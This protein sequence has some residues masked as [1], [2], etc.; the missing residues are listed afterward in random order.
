V[1]GLPGGLGDSVGRGYVPDLYLEIQRSIKEAGGGIE[2]IQC[3]ASNG[4]YS[5]GIQQGLNQVELF[6]RHWKMHSQRK[7]T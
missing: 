3:A 2:D 1:K 6:Q 5:K 4:S 7:V